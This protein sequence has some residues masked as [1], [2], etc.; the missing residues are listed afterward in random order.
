MVKAFADILPQGL[1]L[2]ENAVVKR[3]QVKFPVT[4]LNHRLLGG[5]RALQIPRHLQIA[6]DRLSDRH[7]LPQNGGVHPFVERDVHPFDRAFYPQEI[8]R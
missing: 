2:E 4:H 3:D 1:F 8:M 6:V 7:A 5:D